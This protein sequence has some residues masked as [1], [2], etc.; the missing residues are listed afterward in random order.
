MFGKKRIKPYFA[1]T[2]VGEGRE[3]FDKKLNELISNYPN[4]A[5][6]NIFKINVG[7]EQMCKDTGNDAGD[8]SDN[9]PRICATVIMEKI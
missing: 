2:I 7:I 3:D 1:E 6:K 9:V 5:I 8:S 4:Y